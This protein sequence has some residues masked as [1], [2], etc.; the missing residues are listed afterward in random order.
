MDK[1][2]QTITLSEVRGMLRRLAEA[3]IKQH[4]RYLCLVDGKRTEIVRG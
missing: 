4:G 3:E 1:P 2:K